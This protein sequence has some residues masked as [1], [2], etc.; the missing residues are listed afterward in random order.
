ML[1]LLLLV[2]QQV[3]LCSVPGWGVQKSAVSPG[4]DCRLLL[5]LVLVLQQARW[6]SH[7]EWFPMGAW[8]RLLVDHQQLWLQL[9]LL[10]L[11]Q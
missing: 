4:G 6:R 1:L 5:V 10:L 3:L 9:V 7:R 8:S 2:Q 11:Q